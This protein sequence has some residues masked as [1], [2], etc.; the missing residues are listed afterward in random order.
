MASPR[1][2]RVLKDL[3]LQENNNKCFECG[4]HNPQ[5][6][7]V[8]YGI[9]ICLECSGKHRG[10]GVHLSF[11]RSVSMDKWKDS[12][13][14]KM[15]AGGN[16]KALEFFQSQSDYSDGMSIQ[17]KYNSRAAALL[18]DKITTIAEG[19]P[20]S[21]AT[22]SAKDYVA[23]KPRT[24]LPKSSSYTQNHS[25]GYSNL[26]ADDYQD[27]YQDAEFYKSDSFKKKRDD[28]FD[29]QQRENA[30]R[31]ENLPP[32]QGGKYVGFGSN[33]APQPKGDDFFDSTLSS[34]SSGWSSFTLGASKF[35][36]VA[37]EKAVKAAGVA[38]KKTK[39]FGQSVNESVIK[40][41]KEKVKEG[42]ILDDVSTSM[43]SFANRVKEGTL[44]ND[45]GTSMSG[46]AAKIS[47]KGWS[48]FSLW[49]DAKS[50]TGGPGEK[51]SLL[52]D[53]SSSNDDP[54]ENSLLD[55]EEEDSWGGWEEQNS[56]QNNKEPQTKKKNKPQKLS[57]EDEFEA[58]LN[59]DQPLQSSKT[60]SK[61]KDG[62]DDWG[63]DKTD[64]KSKK[65]DKNVK[66]GGEK[67]SGGD[68]WS[69]V[70]WES[71]FSSPQ[72]Q[73]EP[74]VGNLLDFGEGETG[75]TSS[76][77]DNEVWAAEEENEEDWQ[78]LEESSKLK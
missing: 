5:W 6:V 7:S 26:G 73:K 75:G 39:E 66:K 55:N 31:P 59:D 11:V 16:Q 37:S 34:L 2:K 48:N 68:G 76:G 32:S 15:K 27:S 47:S 78:S 70:N 25:N 50:P 64:K 62:W 17:E 49:G 77:W 14:E 22:S 30:S 43:S 65:S 53:K 24:S 12:E 52:K 33:P 63:E 36:S 10:L 58:W 72:K 35:A 38:S 74:L 29:R 1:T 41:T 28:F 19:K 9:W 67:S 69:D 45:V 60:K 54:S 56:W 46:F 42:K 71:D 61:S 18:R 44:I 23:F 40:P 21:I 3:R 8:S 51:S 4:A 20:W 13:L 57:E